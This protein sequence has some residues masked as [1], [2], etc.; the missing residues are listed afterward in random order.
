MISAGAKVVCFAVANP[1]KDIFLDMLEI[2][3]SLPS[4]SKSNS[5][6]HKPV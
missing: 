1:G 2:E 6:F 4:E 5:I 3:L